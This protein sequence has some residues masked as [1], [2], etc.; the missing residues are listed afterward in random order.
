M[1][2]RRWSMYLSV[3]CLSASAAA[4]VVAVRPPRAVV[5]APGVV[6]VAQPPPAAQVEVAPPS[7]G[8]GYAWEPGYWGWSGTAYVWYPGRYDVRPAGATVWIPA[9]WVARRGRW[10]FRPGHWAYR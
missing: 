3:L 6:V 9:A 10:V 5:V 1:N 4:C 2:H 7:P 8:A